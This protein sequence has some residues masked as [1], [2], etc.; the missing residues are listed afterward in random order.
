M[1][2]LIVALL[3]VIIFLIVSLL[4]IPIFLL[5]GIFDAGLK[6]RLSQRIVSWAFRMLGHIA[7]ARITVKGKD[8]IPKDEAVLY[9]SNHRSIF[10]IV[11]LYAQMFRPTFIISKKEVKW[12]PI[13]N[14]WMVMLH[15]LFMDRADIRQSMTIIMASIENAKNGFS[16]LIYPEGTRTKESELDMHPFKEGSMKI[17]LKSGVKVVPVAMH[18]TR[19]LF[20]AHT[21]FIRAHDVT[22]SF[23]EPI[24]TT[25]LERDEQ[26][27][28]GERCRSEIQKMLE[29][30]AG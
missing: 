30:E 12:V 19:E 14:W 1:I 22:I 9:V 15:C 23:G 16:C 13:L 20:E 8:R 25:A 17:A 2:R 18:G 7:G 3:F 24:D 11:L 5:I 21:P 6:D 10:D 26:K 4:I 27:H 28:L 29:E